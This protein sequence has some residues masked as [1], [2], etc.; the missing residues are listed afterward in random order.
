[1]PVRIK[2]QKISQRDSLRYLSSI[3]SKDVEI[4]ED[5]EHRI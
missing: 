3:I 1:M 4:K 5:V 2:A